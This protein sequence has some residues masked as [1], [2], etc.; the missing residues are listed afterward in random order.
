M[1]WCVTCRR[2]ISNSDGTCPTC[3]ARLERVETES[4]D[5]RPAHLAILDAGGAAAAKDIKVEASAEA[6]AAIEPAGV[7]D[8]RPSEPVVEAATESRPPS[9]A[10]ASARPVPKR[11]LVSSAGPSVPIRKQAN[12]SVPPSWMARLEAAR[13]VTTPPEGGADGGSG[14]AARAPS[15]SGPPPLK[16]SSGENGASRSK[17][18]AH[19]P[20]G[21]PAHLLV[22]QL[23]EEDR[24]RSDQHAE[25]VAALFSNDR[26]DDIAKVEIPLS[27]E[28]LKKKRVPDWVIVTGL[29]VLVIAVV[30]IL[31]IRAKEAPG[32]V[33]QIDPAVQA[34]AEKRRMSIEALEQ[35]HKLAIEG[36]ARADD[37]ILA[38][39]RALDLDPT[40]ASAERGLAIA[41]GLKDDDPNA[42]AHYK[43]YLRLSPSAFDAGDVRK[44]VE[45]Y[46]KKKEAEKAAAQAPPPEP[47]SPPAHKAKHRAGSKKHK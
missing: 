6:A 33:A 36:K 45:R 34:A 3:G 21:R 19:A 29:V 23:E 10:A 16:P 12:D 9:S 1:P 40:L 46:E 7:S 28:G 43:S 11:R 32:P 24:K 42:V 30:G 38:Y 2:E 39:T 44:I 22:A 17:S 5:S 15:S 41:Y 35:G 26:S 25:R 4:T 37:A 14:E 18:G 47:K 31:F 13:V 27:T 8:A 20:V